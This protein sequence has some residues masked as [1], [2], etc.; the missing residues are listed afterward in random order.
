MEVSSKLEFYQGIIKYLLE[1]TSYNLQTIAELTDST[2]NTIQ[3]IYSGEQVPPNFSEHLLV[4]LYLFIL[5]L[6]NP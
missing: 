1:S 6:Q 2:I 4:R 3:S 5:D